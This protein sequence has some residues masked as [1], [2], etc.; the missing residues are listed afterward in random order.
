[1]SV[2]PGPGFALYLDPPYQGR[3]GY[4]GPGVP[5]FDAETF[6]NRCEAWRRAGSVV[7]VSE[8]RAPT[9]AREIFRVE[10]AQGVRTQSGQER[11]TE[12]L[13]VID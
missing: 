4:N 6:W 9:F 7:I 3:T 8:Y 1:M 10:R 5:K 13:F 11:R 12:K 2:R